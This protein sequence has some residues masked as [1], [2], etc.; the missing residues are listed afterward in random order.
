[1]SRLRWMSV[2]ALSA[3]AVLLLA[4]VAAGKA[5]SVKSTV[6]ISSGEGARFTGKVVAAKKKCRANRTVKLYAEAEAGSAYAEAGSAR[7]GDVLVDVA[8]T[9]ATGAWRMD[10]NFYAGVY[11]AQVLALL[12]TIDGDPFR[13]APDLSLRMQY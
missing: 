13:C 11:Y 7:P 1:M 8:K 9:D 3:L 10:G 2:L 5:T 4:S 6:T 12:V